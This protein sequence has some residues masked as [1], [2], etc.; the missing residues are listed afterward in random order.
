M[1][2]YEKYQLE[3]LHGQQICFRSI[4]REKIDLK[5]YIRKNKARTWAI[6]EMRK[7]AKRS[8]RKAD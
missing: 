5:Y 6:L 3:G 2:K 8:Y 7:S 1:P 4:K